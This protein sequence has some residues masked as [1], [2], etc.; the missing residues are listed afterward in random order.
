MPE[1]ELSVNFENS[2]DVT[3]FAEEEYSNPS[4]EQTTWFI[5]EFENRLVGL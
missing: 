2:S 4:K 1:I 5:G 3:L